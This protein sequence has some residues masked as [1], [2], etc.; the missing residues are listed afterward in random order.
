MMCGP[1]PAVDAFRLTLMKSQLASNALEWFINTVNSMEY[2]PTGITTFADAM[3]ALHRRFVTSSNAQR[4]TRAFDAVRYDDA[5]GPDSFAE[6]LIKRG[7]QMN[8]K[9]DEFA[10]NRKFLAGLPDEIRYKLKVDRQ[11]TAEYTPFTVLRADARQLWSAETEEKAT[12]TAARAAARS[13]APKAAVT[14]TAPARRPAARTDA[15]TPRS[16][17]TSQPYTGYAAHAHPSPGGPTRTSASGDKRT[18]FKCGHVGHIGSDPS[19][20]RYNDPPVLPGARVGAQRV[21]ESYADGGLPPDDVSEYGDDEEIVQDGTMEGLWG[22]QY[23]P[24][25]DPNE[26]PDLA[27]LVDPDESE[28]V[29]VGAIRA[30]YYS[31]RIEEV[32]VVPGVITATPEEETPFD[33]H[34]AEPLTL[35]MDRLLLTHPGPQH[36]EWSAAEEVR[37]ASANP[38]GSPIPTTRPCSRT[39]NLAPATPL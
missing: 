13:A 35:D 8:H 34:V 24:D 29:R 12:A 5:R 11:L 6:A 9:P 26:S 3:C 14:A 21:V 32:E 30:R 25:F 20:P 15:V 31:M 38:L 23:D 18:C 7:N 39:S 1:D 37:L 10:M 28:G 17:G 16:A 22:G 33:V 4:A 36:P 19:C 2:G 27:E